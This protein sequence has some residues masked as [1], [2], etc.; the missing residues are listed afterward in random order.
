MSKYPILL[1]A[2]NDRNIYEVPNIP[3]CG[4][5][6]GQYLRLK[7][8]DLIP[9]PSGSELFIL[10][11]R[12][13]VGIDLESGLPQNIIEN[14]FAPGQSCYPVAAFVS[15]GYTQVQT[16]AYSEYEKTDYNSSN[17]V[18]LPLFSYS[19]AAWFKNKIHVAA[20]RVD[21]QRR[22]DLRLMNLGLVKK[23]TAVFQKI[24][25]CNRL[26]KHLARCAL[27]YC[28]PAARN[29]FLQRYECP[30]PA[31][32]RCNARCLGCISLQPSGCCP[33]TQPRIDFRP[34]PEEIAEVALFHIKNVR[35]PVVSFGQ[36]CEGEPL[37]VYKTL[38]QAIKLIRKQTKKGTINLNTNASRPEAVAELAQS[39]LDSIRVS[40]NSVREK[41]YSAYYRP[42]SYKFRDVLKSISVMKSYNRFVSINYLTLPG[43]T[44]LPSEVRAL[45]K[46]ITN[47][48]IDM[49]QWRNL[50]YDPL[51]YIDSLGLNKNSSKKEKP[52]GLKILLKNLRQKF[53]K[54]K[55][56]Y[57]NPYLPSPG[58]NIQL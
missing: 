23:N 36:G 8:E 53:P 15:P 54:L 5:Q 31:S 41:Y 25:P 27:T 37:L 50:N 11:D 19:A 34:A 13:P 22:Q 42:A 10:P 56:G 33:A 26:V 20:L 47:K 14:P 7:P 1:I 30:L 38:S 16:A 3:A 12:I 46:L 18:I 4:M 45:E 44:D 21:R 58:K 51:R 6:T 43:F 49:I 9:L 48:K 29:F 17:T 35:Q 2:D 39:G 57:F 55:F 32:P 40:L 52:I 28:C 24:M